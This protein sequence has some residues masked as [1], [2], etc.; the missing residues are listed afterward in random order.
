MQSYDE[1]LPFYSFLAGVFLERKEISYSELSFLMDDFTNL[2]GIYI[3]DEN[4]LFSE[5][6]LFFEFNDRGLY[7]NVDYDSIVYIN[8]HSMT[9]KKYLYSIT[10]KEVK[11]YFKL[12]EKSKFVFFKSKIKTKVS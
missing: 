10:S 9:F 5:F 2:T 4:E 8:G 6:D 11:K 7:I 12:F 3:S 1:I